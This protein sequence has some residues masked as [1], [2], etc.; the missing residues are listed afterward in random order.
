[1]THYNLKAIIKIMHKF[2]DE[3]ESAPKWREKEALE[4]FPYIDISPE[5]YAANEAHKWLSFSFDD[6]IYSNK[7]LN[8]WIHSLGDIF[9]TPGKVKEARKNYLTGDQI[10]M[11][12]ELEQDS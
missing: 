6:Y 2:I 4:L 9:F 3:Y 11:I 8:E 5:E 1:M 10:K 12:E 7:I